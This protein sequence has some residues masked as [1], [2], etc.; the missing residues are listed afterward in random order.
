M[1]SDGLHFEVPD[2]LSGCKP[3]HE[4]WLLAEA[5]DL[6]PGLKIAELGSGVGAVALTLAAAERVEVVG[7]EIQP[8]LVEVARHNA[9]TN[10][11]HL[12]GKVRFVEAELRT[13]TAPLDED[14]FD[15]VVANPPF[16]QK[17]QGRSSP[18]ALRN[19]ARRETSATLED[20]VEVASRILRKQGRLHLILRPDRLG[21]LLTLM[22]RHSCPAKA[23]E[24]VYT[25]AERDAKWVIVKGAK[26]GRSG[27]SL[28]PAK[29]LWEKI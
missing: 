2:D 27:L 29:R 26:G 20:F 10:A 17:R 12:R 16:Y 8:A 7:F 1:N 18:S 23:V 15:C 3:G 4:T 9:A 25:H 11:A 6:K 28:R 5:V 19:T 22:D 13:L 14:R 21:E 24:P